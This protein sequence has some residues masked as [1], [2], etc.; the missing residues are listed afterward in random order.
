MT[1]TPQRITRV[2]AIVDLVVHVIAA[3]AAMTMLPHGFG[4]TDIHLW[5]N[6]VIP[7]VS[8]IATV[9]VLVRLLFF[10][11]SAVALSV[12]MAALAGG[13][14]GAV[15]TGVVLFPSS[16]TL[17]RCAAAGGVALAFLAVA[18]WARERTT[19]TL[20]GLGAGAALG[21]VL[22][23]AQRAPAP[24]TRPLGGTLAE[25]RG[26]D[27]VEEAA[28]GQIV[29]G[30]GKG[31]LRISPLLSFQSRSPDRTWTVLAPDEPAPR[32]VLTHYAKTPTGFRASYTDDGSSTLVAVKDNK[33]GVVELD[34]VS[35]LGQ[36]V[37]SHLNSWT[38]I[39]VT[40]DATLSFSPTG[41]TRFAIEPADYPTG[42]PAQLAYLGEDLSFRVVRARDAEKGPFTELA[43]GHL[44]RDE[45]LVLEI[46]PRN[47]T[48]K[49]DKGCVLVFKDWS[50]QVST[51]PSP[52]AGWGV[53]QNSI[54]FFTRG[55]EG[56]VLLALAETGPGRGWDS[57]AHAE[58]T[59]RN[60]LR[61]APLK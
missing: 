35:K 13:W 11:S 6:T 18:V 47:E 7:A 33:S 25:M 50:A 9:I 21:F 17:G 51:E 28:T 27:P 32:R 48:D 42:R 10:G 12:L 1:D 19:P 45:P 38:M 24:S 5:S 58:G 56:L 2:I 61:V 39:H 26:E 41:P 49:T 44:G 14:M 20:V 37:Y 3:G 36:P 8:V 43:K 22:V 53:P 31:K 34:A 46:R 55:S 29:V 30:C 59:Y 40:F 57:V 16:M 15:I 60:R 23:L 4:L 54:Q 52:T